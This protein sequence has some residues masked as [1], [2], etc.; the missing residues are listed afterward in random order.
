[1]GLLPMKKRIFLVIGF[2][3]ILVITIVLLFATGPKPYDPRA[4]KEPE[5]G[6]QASVVIDNTER[7]SDLLLYNQ[8]IAVKDTLSSYILSETKGE[9]SF[10]EILLG[11]TTLSDDGSIRFKVKA[12]GL[13][14][15][16]DIVVG[17]PSTAEL[18]FTVPEKNYSITIYPYDQ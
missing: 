5:K 7:L 11:S 6:G 13:D 12:E 15:E 18:T 1:M 2:L 4:P 14:K 8:F 3:A 10:A 16:L 9:A 17:R